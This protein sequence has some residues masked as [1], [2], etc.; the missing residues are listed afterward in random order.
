MEW[1]KFTIGGFDNG[2][3]SDDGYAKNVT[4][5]LVKNQIR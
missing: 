3:G 2:F 1:A 4:I 5:Y